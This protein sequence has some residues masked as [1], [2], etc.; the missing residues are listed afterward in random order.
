LLCGC[1]PASITAAHQQLE[2][3]GTRDV[4]FTIPIVQDTLTVGEFVGDDTTTTA[5]G[6]LAVTMDPETLGVA[7]GQR[8]TFTNLTFTRTEVDVP[9]GSGPG[10]FP[11]NVM[12]AALSN[13]PRI[14][15]ID[16]VVAAS[17]T[18]TVTTR[19]RLPGVLTYTLTLAGFRD[20]LGAT[21]TRNGN[22]PAAPG[23]GS[24]TS[25]SVSFDLTR[26]RITPGS[27]TVTLAGSVNLTGTTT[28]AVADS[29]VIQTGTGNIVVERLR[30]NLDPAVTP[31]LV[32]AVEEFDEFPA[33]DVDFGQLE[34]PIRDARLND[35]RLA[36]TARNTSQAPLVAAGFNLGV[37]RLTASGQIPRDASNNPIYEA[38]SLGVIQIPVTDSGGTTLTV[39]RGQTKTVTLQAARLIDRVLELLLSNQRAGIVGQGTVRVGDG[40][41]S[42]ISRGDSANLRVGVTVALDFSI[43][44][45]GVT[46]DTLTNGD[47]AAMNSAEVADV[48]GHLVSAG[49]RLI[50]TNGT[51]FGVSVQASV[52]PDTLLPGVDVDSVF[53]MTNRVDLNPVQVSPAPA[54]AQG[55]VVTPALDTADI[56][57][58]GQQIGVVLGEYFGAGLRVRLLA[59]AGGRGAI[60]ASDRVIVRAS[61]TVRFRTGGN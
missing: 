50:V 46:F 38:D 59:G 58:T 20:S 15:A 5:E 3:D 28:A 54:D 56:A 27:V 17:G 6:L 53:R 22:V 49:A 16:T 40:A 4:E 23:D 31:E 24:Y 13:E 60:R 61:A 10:N 44:V 14:L 42:T 7:V 29:S 1:E 11:V 48:T 52:V 9:A 21:L 12:Y 43:P 19:N 57:L 36:L 33:A 8:L 25:G 41:A 45:A 32:I 51:P 18:I 34:D 55:R 2:R 39:A 26:V 37:V 47:G 30:G 35:V